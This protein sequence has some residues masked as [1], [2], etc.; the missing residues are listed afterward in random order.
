MRTCN[1]SQS[2]RCLES[3]YRY[4]TSGLRGT[5]AGPC[6]GLNTAGVDR[7]VVLSYLLWLLNHYESLCV[8]LRNWGH[9]RDAPPHAYPLDDIGS[10][11]WREL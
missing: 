2:H 7:A 4:V 9:A 3:E 8:S 1:S 10:E 5:S 6:D 11:G